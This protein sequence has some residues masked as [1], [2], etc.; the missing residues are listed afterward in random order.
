MK[1]TEKLQLLEN[2]STM[3]NLAAWIGYGVMVSMAV[4][5]VA[6]LVALAAAA[7][8]ASLRYFLDAAG[9]VP[10]FRE[11]LQWRERE[12]REGKPCAK[13]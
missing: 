4:L 5:V 3:D 12:Q 11:F 9:G 7:L 1:L 10:L 2:A 8:C 6:A 13:E